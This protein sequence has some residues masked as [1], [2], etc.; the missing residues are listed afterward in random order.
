MKTVAELLRIKPARVVSVGPTQSVLEAIK[1]LAA[2]DIGAAIVMEGGRR[3]TFAQETAS[4]GGAG[5]QAGQHGLEGDE[6][7]QM[8]V[9]GTEH[10]AHASCP[11]HLNL[12]DVRSDEG[13]RQRLNLQVLPSHW[14]IHR[15]SISRA[16]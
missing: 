2:E 16:R 15:R 14:K 9:F 11:Q 5:G 6:T 12:G 13:L 7:L 10:D 8:R 1:V 3:P 4:G